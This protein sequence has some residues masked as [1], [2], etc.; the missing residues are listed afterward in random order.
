MFVALLLAFPW[1]PLNIQ[2]DFREQALDKSGTKGCDT[3]HAVPQLLKFQE[4]AVAGS[5]NTEREGFEPSVRLRAH[6]F[7]RPA[8][9]TTLASLRIVQSTLILRALFSRSKMG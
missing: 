8:Q 4:P 1:Q 9:S 7:S 2:M 6:R 5:W 3:Q